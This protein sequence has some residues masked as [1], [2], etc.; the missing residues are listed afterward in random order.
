MASN[1]NVGTKSGWPEAWP[2]LPGRRN[3]HRRRGRVGACERRDGRGVRRRGGRGDGARRRRSL[4][5]P[6]SG[7]AGSS[8]TG[9]RNCRKPAFAGVGQGGPGAVHN[10]FG[11][12]RITRP[13][14]SPRHAGPRRASHEHG[15]P[16]PAKAC[17]R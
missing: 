7:G 10:L 8:H 16:A 6:V 5:R 4:L 12:I 1:G 14:T 2:F 3:V 13:R 15:W 17:S 9:L 11:K